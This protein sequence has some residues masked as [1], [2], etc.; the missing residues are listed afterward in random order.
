MKIQMP[1]NGRA[2]NPKE[3]RNFAFTLGK[4]DYLYERNLSD[5]LKRY[6]SR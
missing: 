6:N 2:Y 5:Y 4:M 3:Y 1:F